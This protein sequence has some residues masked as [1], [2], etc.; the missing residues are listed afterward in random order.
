MISPMASAARRQRPGTGRVASATYG[1]TRLQLDGEAERIPQRAVGVGEGRGTGPR[2]R[3]RAGDDDLAVAGEDLRLE[4]RLVRQ[5]GPER[6]RLDAQAG[7]RPAEGDRAQLRD[8]KGHEAVRKGRG[9]QVLVRRHALDARGRGSPG[10]GRRRGS[11]PRRRAGPSRSCAGG[12]GW[13]CAS[14]AGPARPVAGRP[15]RR[16]GGR[17]R[18]GAARRRPVRRD[19]LRHDPMKPASAGR[20]AGHPRVRVRAGR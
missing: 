2:A 15:G 8:D 20:R 1:C 4:H 3:R 18:R 16:A 6:G 13:T 12:R 19:S 10:R 17:S 7:D 11:G 9:D 14:P 5:P